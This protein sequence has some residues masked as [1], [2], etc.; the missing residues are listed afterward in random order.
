M[1]AVSVNVPDEHVGAVT[2]YLSGKRGI[3]KNMLQR[4]KMKELSAVAPLAEL[5]GMTSDL[6]NLT[7]GTAAAT[8]EPSHYEEVPGGVMKQILGEDK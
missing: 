1:M 2:G 3:I 4:G 5:F 6:R 7:S 8:M